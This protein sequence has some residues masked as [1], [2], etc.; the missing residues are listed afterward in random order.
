MKSQ[1]RKTT[2]QLIIILLSLGIFSC[3]MQEIDSPI[4]E[5]NEMEFLAT[6]IS[7]SET[8]PNLRVAANLIF[9]ET[10]E[11]NN[12]LSF[13]WKQLAS[14]HS[15]G[16]PTNPKFQ[17]AKSGKFELRYGDKVQINSGVRAEVLFPAQ[18]H[19]ERWYSFAV[20]FPSDGFQM[21]TDT[22]IISQ[23]HQEGMGSPSASLN[24]KNDRLI[25]IVGNV[26]TGSSNKDNIDL[27]QVP[28]NSWNEFVF[29]YIH[30]NGSDG[31]IEVWQNGKKIVTRRG[32]NIYK[33]DLPKWKIGLYKWTWAN[34]KTNVSKRIIY[35]DNVRM[36]NQNAS[37]NDMTSSGTTQSSSTDT[38]ES[39]PKSTTTTSSGSSPITGFSLIQANINKYLQEISAGNVIPT[40]THK[41]N[42]QA[43][44]VTG[45]K[46]SV[47]FS[48]TGASTQNFTDQTAPFT[49]FGDDGRGNYYFGTGLPKG[50]Y[51]LVAMPSTGASKTIKFTLR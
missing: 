2:N 28:K 6:S 49:L 48:L 11:G 13:T 24:V 1:M 12:P 39:S 46:G 5:A 42:I 47:S 4:A 23:W 15:F 8:D 35:F 45:F 22:E 31:L 33:G 16:T 19:R 26:Q 9:E 41:M 10:F 17:G 34:R 43:N 36:G 7:D 44:M 21:D 40:T 20:N 27:G 18:N 3:E 25:L 37:F 29:H 14:S 30:S 32:G 51:T 38:A 50:D